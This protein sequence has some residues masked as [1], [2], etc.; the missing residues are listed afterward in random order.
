MAQAGQLNIRD[1]IKKEYKKC[2]IDPAYFMSKFCIIQHPIRGKVAFNLYDFKQETLNAFVDNRYNI[3]LKARQIVLSTLVAGYALWMMLFGSD[4]NVLVIA[5]T[6]DTAKNLVTTVR[7]M[8]QNL[9]GW[10]R[11]DCT[12]DNKLSLAFANGSQIKAIASSPDAGRSEALSLL[13]LDEAAFI[14]F[15][16]EI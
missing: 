16:E 9:R 1:I 14:D 6:Q 7:I 2:A 4:Q 3:V 13:I 15:A 8:H 5:T 12:E 11:G 10:L